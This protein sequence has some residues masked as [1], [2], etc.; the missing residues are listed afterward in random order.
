MLGTVA[1]F[2]GRV[3]GPDDRGGWWL[4]RG[5]SD[6]AGDVSAAPLLGIGSGMSLR[7]PGT[8]KDLVRTL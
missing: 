2:A 5:G 6:G 8:V 3:G 4:S 1:A 7:V